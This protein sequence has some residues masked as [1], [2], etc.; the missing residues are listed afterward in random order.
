MAPTT[1]ETVESA[2]NKLDC[3]SRQRNATYV[4]QTKIEVR[5]K[6][7]DEAKRMAQREKLPSLSDQRDEQPSTSRRRSCWMGLHVKQAEA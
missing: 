2:T 1:A 6:A 3:R 4:R 5:R 7:N